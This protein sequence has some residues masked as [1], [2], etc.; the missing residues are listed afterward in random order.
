MSRCGRHAIALF[1]LLACLRR[2]SIEAAR[3]PTTDAVVVSK[4]GTATVTRDELTP[5]SR[6]AK[7]LTLVVG[8]LID[9]DGTIMEIPIIVPIRGCADFSSVLQALRRLKSRGFK[10]IIITNQSGIGRGLFTLDQYRAVG[11]SEVYGSLATVG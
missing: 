11:K 10:L 8:C 5:V 1:T 6:T 4:L 7:C 3:L 2:D 9:R